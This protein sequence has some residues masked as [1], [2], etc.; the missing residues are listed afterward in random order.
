MASTR[1]WFD[2]GNPRDAGE[3]YAC[4]TVSIDCDIFLYYSI[5]CLIS[6]S[7]LII[8]ISYK[9]SFKRIDLYFPCNNLIFDAIN[10]T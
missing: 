1:R 2:R 3:W 4:R 10:E 5:L 6:Y 9:V 8:T 7:V